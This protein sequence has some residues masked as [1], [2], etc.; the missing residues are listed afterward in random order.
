[1]PDDISMETIALGTHLYVG[2]M[3]ECAAPIHKYL[4]FTALLKTVRK[5]FFQ[6]KLKG[7]ALIC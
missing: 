6:T 3:D 2:I 5:L 4:Y 1:M 7:I